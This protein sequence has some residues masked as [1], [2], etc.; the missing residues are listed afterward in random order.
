VDVCPRPE[1]ALAALIHGGTSAPWWANAL[2]TKARIIKDYGNAAA[3][4]TPAGQRHRRCAGAVS[5][6]LL[7]GAN[8]LELK[9][10]T[11]THSAAQAR[12]A[13]FR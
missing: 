9:N 6:Q 12:Y 2:V 10:Q 3:H 1:P 7:A 5:F 13:A 11:I 4:E 8:L